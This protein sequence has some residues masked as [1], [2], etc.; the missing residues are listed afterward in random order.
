MGLVRN[1]LL[2]NGVIPTTPTDREA[3]IVLYVTVD[4]FGIVRSRFDTLLYN[5][6]K[7]QAETAFEMMAYDKDGKLVMAPQ[8]SNRMAQYIEH[9]L[10]WSGPVMTSEK[11][12][13]GEGLLVN[14]SN[15][16]GGKTTFNSG[17][18]VNIYHFLGKN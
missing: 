7:V 10:L 18:D 5:S 11:I 8:S 1:Y 17:K 12:Q 15:V 3:E 14:F 2:L 13:K 6:E 4:I 16:N 9:Y